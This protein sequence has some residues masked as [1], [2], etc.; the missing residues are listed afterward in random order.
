MHWKEKNRQLEID[1]TFA[2]FFCWSWLIGCAGILLWLFCRKGRQRPW[3]K[4][5]WVSVKLCYLVSRE[6]ERVFDPLT[7]HPGGKAKDF[8]GLWSFNFY[9]PR[10]EIDFPAPSPLP[11]FPERGLGIKPNQE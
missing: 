6:R 9:W 5:L 10:G 4:W 3:W 2:S 8:S 7:A 1:Q 11:A